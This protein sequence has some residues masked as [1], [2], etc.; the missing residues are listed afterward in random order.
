MSQTKQTQ[1][2]PERVSIS[3]AVLNTVLQILSGLP[4]SQV[5]N[6]IAEVQQDVQGLGPAPTPAVPTKPLNTDPVEEAIIVEDKNE[7][8]ADK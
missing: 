5:A 6:T 4:Y 3:T 2:M 7:P 1:E 8:E